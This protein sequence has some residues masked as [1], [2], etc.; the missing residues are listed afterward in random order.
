MYVFANEYGTVLKY[1][2][3]VAGMKSHTTFEPDEILH[4]IFDDDPDNEMFGMSPLETALW[5]ARTDIA[6]A[7]SNYH[8][9]EN[10][11]VPAT[12]Y[13]TEQG[14]TEDAQKAVMEMIK[15]SFSGAKNRNKSAILSGIKEIKQISMSQKDMEFV[16]GRKFNTD[17]VCSVYGVPKFVIGYTE[18]VNYS[19]GSK[20]LEKFYEGTIKPLEDLLSTLINEQLLPKLGIEAHFEF[21]PQ[22]FGEE[23]EIT[24]MA[25]DEL[26]AG[27]LTLRQYKLKTG[28]DI[29][30]E[31]EEEILIDRHIIHS[32]ASAVLME[33]VGVD[34]IID[35]N[36]PQ[37]AE[38][39]INALKQYEELH[40]G[41]TK[42]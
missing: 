21:I 42:D 30:P 40:R 35:P 9:F 3:Q 19:S 41:T 6:A 16:V 20:L 26:R 31:D 25:L 24:R 37:T 8:F 17:K 4:L 28:Q 22:N 13:V 2:Q 38:N 34:P 14:I 12:M 33:D 29:T 11:A 27:A 23:S 39:M 10:D 36:D 15:E 1:V 5:E 18:T 32:G 7:Q